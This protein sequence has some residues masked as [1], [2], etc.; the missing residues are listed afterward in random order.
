VKNAR[1]RRRGGAG[2][3]LL[4]RGIRA[5]TTPT[6]WLNQ[7]SGSDQISWAARRGLGGATLDGQETT[8]AF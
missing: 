4:V 6:D 2:T 5:N 1:L 3:H 8:T 7:I